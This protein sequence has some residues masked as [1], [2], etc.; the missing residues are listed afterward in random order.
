ML[1]FTSMVG[2]DWALKPRS[3]V[4]A[5]LLKRS[6]ATLERPS[7]LQRMGRLGGL[8]GAAPMV[9]WGLWPEMLGPLMVYNLIKTVVV[10]ITYLGQNFLE[11]CESCWSLNQFCAY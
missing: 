11:M 9:G 7:G 8:L 5:Q 3:V 6:L 1:G 10:A 2:H 4:Q